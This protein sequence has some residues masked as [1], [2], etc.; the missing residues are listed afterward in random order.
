V[1]LCPQLRNLVAEHARWRAGMA[2]RAG[3]TPARRAARVLSLWE[4]EIL[5]RC[6][7]EEEVL[8][9]ELSRCRSEA[10]AM[11]VF[12]VGDHMLLRRLAKDLRIASPNE[13]AAALRELEAKLTEH[14]EF[15][16]RTLFPGLQDAL[17]C[18]RLAGLAADLDSGTR[19]EPSPPG[20]GE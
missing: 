10:D 12:T 5:P 14:L 3:E 4:R 13:R 2:Q 1:N 8:L 18:D 16:E 17:G 6:R 11:L 7:A 19:R 15:E 9:P 20:K